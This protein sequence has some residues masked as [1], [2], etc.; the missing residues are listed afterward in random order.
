[1]RKSSE[2]QSFKRRHIKFQNKLGFLTFSDRDKAL[3]WKTTWQQE[4]TFIQ[5]LCFMK[6]EFG[7]NSFPKTSFEGARQVWLHYSPEFEPF[8]V[9]KLFWLF[10]TNVHRFKI[11][12]S[13]SDFL[14][15]QSY[16][17]D[18][19]LKVKV[20][21]IVNPWEWPFLR[22]RHHSLGLLSKNKVPSR[23]DN[24]CSLSLLLSLWGT[25]FFLASNWIQMFFLDFLW[26]GA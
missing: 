13:Q 23:P 12:D 4:K 18:Q 10:Y 26:L 21:E 6:S 11:Y 19:L 24:T 25:L 16:T 22:H 14:L 1:M 15:L 20:A 3:Y 7:G 2:T 9:Y 5:K 8:Y 17:G